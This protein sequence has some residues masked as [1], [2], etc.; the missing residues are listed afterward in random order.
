M[1]TPDDLEDETMWW[2][3]ENGQPKGPLKTL[4]MVLQFMSGRVNDDTLVWH[5]GMEGWDRASNVEEL[6]EFVSYLNSTCV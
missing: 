5:A 4:D 6:M 1:S 3:G 2:W